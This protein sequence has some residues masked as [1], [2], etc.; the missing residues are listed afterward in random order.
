M[1]LQS[2]CQICGNPL[3][4]A[5][6]RLVGVCNHSKCLH[7]W[8]RRL[9]ALRQA[10][11]EVEREQRQGLAAAYRDQEAARLG[12]TGPETI[13]PVAVLANLRRIINLP[14]RRRRAFRDRLMESLSQAAASRAS[15]A[16]RVS[17]DELQS[18]PVVPPL[19]FD[20]FLVRGCATCRGRC[21]NN[22]HEYA[23][24]DAPTLE[25]YMRRHPDQRP[26][27]VLEDYLSRIP[28]KSYENSCVYQEEAGC[29]LPHEMRATICNEF[30][31]TELRYFQQQSAGGTFREVM[32]VALEGT[33]VIRAEPLKAEGGVPP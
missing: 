22:G 20:P 28:N 29:V 8:T 18:S 4:E 25:A 11:M 30:Y 5:R 7:A 6:W 10:E 21:C 17:G 33:R 23:Y 26:R 13:L 15:S 14:E 9:Q 32:F 24:Q 19:V 1:T 16:N 31:C 12:I 27:H 3:I 2:A